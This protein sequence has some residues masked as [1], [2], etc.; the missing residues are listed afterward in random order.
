M[1]YELTDHECRRVA[2]RYHK[3]AANYLAF[4]QLASVRLWLRINESTTW[5]PFASEVRV[6]KCRDVSRTSEAGH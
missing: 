2:T 3:L 1:S 6:R 4:I 5:C